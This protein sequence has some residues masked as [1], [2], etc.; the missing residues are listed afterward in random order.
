MLP[1]SIALNYQ[2]VYA[3]RFRHIHKSQDEGGESEIRAS[4]AKLELSFALNT[5][6]LI[7]ATSRFS[8]SS[9]PLQEANQ[10]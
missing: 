10:P 8:H 7:F 1:S 2:L 4:S 6:P 5:S 3:W 9:S